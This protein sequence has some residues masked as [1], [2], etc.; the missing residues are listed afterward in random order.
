MDL[1]KITKWL[2]FLTDLNEDEVRHLATAVDK[3]FGIINATDPSQTSTKIIF[4][5]KVHPHVFRAHIGEGWIE[6]FI[7]IEN[8]DDKITY[9]IY[10]GVPVIK[11]EYGEVV[12]QQSFD[13]YA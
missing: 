2:F 13:S 3:Y 8:N 5:G 6:H 10:N 1:K 7:P 11:R 9:E 4:N 12:V